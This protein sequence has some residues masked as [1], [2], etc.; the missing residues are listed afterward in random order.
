[1]DIQTRDSFF[2]LNHTLYILNT[3]PKNLYYNYYAY[4]ANISIKGT[5]ELH[6]INFT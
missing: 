1:M 5:T 2:K 6:S 4:I 3:F